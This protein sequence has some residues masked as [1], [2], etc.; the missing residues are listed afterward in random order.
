MDITGESRKIEVTKLNELYLDMDHEST[1]KCALTPIT[2]YYKQ[3]T[4]RNHVMLKGL[5]NG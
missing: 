1:R 5:C 3:L 2:T 4:I